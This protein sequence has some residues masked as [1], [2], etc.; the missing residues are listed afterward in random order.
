MTLASLLLTA[1]SFFFCRLQLQTTALG[2]DNQHL[3]AASYLSHYFNQNIELAGDNHCQAGQT[4]VN[5]AQA[6]SNTLPSDLKRKANS[7]AC[8]VGRC[9][10]FKGRTQFMHKA[11]YLAKSPR[12]SSSGQPIYGLFQK[13]IGCAKSQQAEELVTDVAQF[14]IHYFMRRQRGDIIEVTGDHVTDWRSVVAV[15]IQVFFHT[16]DP[17]SH[18]LWYYFV[19]LQERLQ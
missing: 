17:R 13:L 11:I 7:D 10:R 14:H 2:H 1:V 12:F 15:G 16:S 4:P 3:M 8:V 9:L 18:K 6:L 5:E 19:H